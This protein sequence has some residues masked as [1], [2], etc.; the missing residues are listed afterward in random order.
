MAEVSVVVF[1]LYSVLLMR[2]FIHASER[3]MSLVL[4]LKDIFT[5]TNLAVAFISGL[6]GCIVLEYLRKQP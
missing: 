1:L 3:G 5:L 4:A 2:E 6:I